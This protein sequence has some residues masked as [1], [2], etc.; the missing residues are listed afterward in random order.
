MKLEKY[1]Q[2]NSIV[3]TVKKGRA[4]SQKKEGRNAFKILTGKNLVVIVPDRYLNQRLDRKFTGSNSDYGKI[5]TRNRHS[6]DKK[7]QQPKTKTP[8]LCKRNLFN[9]LGL[10]NIIFLNIDSFRK[11]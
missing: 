2:R 5:I 1:P 8:N 10:N 4:Y 7:P 6:K 9:G 11:S 3:Y